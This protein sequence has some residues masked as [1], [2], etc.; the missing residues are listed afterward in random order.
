MEKVH[1]L[2]AGI[3]PFY[4]RVFHRSGTIGKHSFAGGRGTLEA[5][6]KLLVRRELLPRGEDDSNRVGTVFERRKKLARVLLSRQADS[7]QFFWDRNT[8]EIRSLG[9]GLQCAAR[10]AS[11]AAVARMREV[12]RPRRTIVNESGCFVRSFRDLALSAPLAQRLPRCRRGCPGSP[13]SDPRDNW[14]VRS[15]P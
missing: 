10:G 8:N 11:S 15:Q 2:V 9:F 7:T 3:P 13:P 14:P 12:R 1:C 5:G 4:P 6:S